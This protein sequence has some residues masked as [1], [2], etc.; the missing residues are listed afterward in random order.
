MWQSIETAPKDGTRILVC[1][2]SSNPYI[3]KVGED[4]WGDFGDKGGWGKSNPETI[5]THWMPLPSPPEE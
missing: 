4:Y 3:P 2:Y 5:P 1:R